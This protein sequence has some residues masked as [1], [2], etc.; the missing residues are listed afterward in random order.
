MAKSTRHRLFLWVPLVIAALLIG[1]SLNPG[2]T[3]GGPALAT[4]RLVVAGAPFVLS[5]GDPECRDGSYCMYRNENYNEG[6]TAPDGSCDKAAFFTGQLDNQDLGGVYRGI[7]IRFR[8]CAS[9]VLNRTTHRMQNKYETGYV[10]YIIRCQ[11]GNRNLGATI[12]QNDTAAVISNAA[13][14]QYFDC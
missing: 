14:G 7:D 3:S 12:G 10:Q 8:Y 9:S 1:L 5:A 4:D 13:F 11:T 6:N 2:K